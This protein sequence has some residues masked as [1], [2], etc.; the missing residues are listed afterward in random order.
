MLIF[1]RSWKCDMAML[2]CIRFRIIVFSEIS[3]I[4]CF[5]IQK[6]WQFEGMGEG[7]LYIPDAKNKNEKSLPV[8][9]V[10][11]ALNEES[12]IGPTL[13]EFLDSYYY[14]RVL[15]V[16]GHSRDRTVEIA[17]NLGANIAF[18]D[19]MGKGNAIAKALEHLDLDVKYL[20]LT[21]ADHTYP[22]EYVPEMIGILERNPDVGMVC[23]DRFN[24]KTEAGAVR[25]SFYFG[26]R[27]LAFA[28]SVFNGISLRDPLTGLRVIRADVLRDWVV[29]SQGFDI[30]V[31]LNLLV[32]RRGYRTVEVP[33]RYR[34]RLGEKKLKVRHGV[35]ILKRILQEASPFQKSS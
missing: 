5:A 11:A 27:L 14:P 20:V 4:T 10:V 35:T 6:I 17:K 28:H 3:F 16:D 13:T 34:E 1:Q 26:N 21:D 2:T 29:K 32:E 22:G 15:V 24:G 23:G 19:S 18:Q 12:G 31:E 9:L 25:S 8:Q 33:I 30:E 7:L